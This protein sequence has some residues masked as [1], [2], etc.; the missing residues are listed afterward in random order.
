MQAR[1]GKKRAF[2]YAQKLRVGGS[3]MHHYAVWPRLHEEDFERFEFVSD[4]SVNGLR[5]HYHRYGLGPDRRANAVW[6]GC[7]GDVEAPRAVTVIA[8]TEVAWEALDQERIGDCLNP[9]L[10]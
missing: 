7:L 5:N 4:Y 10:A 9:P 6:N 1:T 3:A 2:F 8:P